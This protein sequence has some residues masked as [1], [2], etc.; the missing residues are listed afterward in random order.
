M[1]RWFTVKL[2]F[3]HVFLVLVALIIILPL[4]RESPVRRIIL[5]AMY[6]VIF[7][8]ILYDL[9]RGRG[10]RHYHFLIGVPWIIFGWLSIVLTHLL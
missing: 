3:S 10:K 6:T 4:F 5:N 7:I 8:I 1:E 9:S 2:R